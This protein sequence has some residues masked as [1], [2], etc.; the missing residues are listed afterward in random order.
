MTKVIKC[1]CGFVVS[2]DTE[3]ELV[4]AARRHAKEVHDM[5]LTTE[6]IL[7]MAEPAN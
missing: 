6:Q 1:D 5:H 2:G 4:S 3:D 7:A